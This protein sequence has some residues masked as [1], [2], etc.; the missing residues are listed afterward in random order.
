[1]IRLYKTVAAEAVKLLGGT[2]PRAC[3]ATPPRQMFGRFGPVTSTLLEAEAV[4]RWYEQAA[5]CYAYLLDVDTT[6]NEPV[7]TQLIESD[8]FT[9]GWT[10]QEL[11]APKVIE[12]YDRNWTFMGTRKSLQHAVSQASSIPAEFLSGERHIQSAFIAQRMS[13]AAS[14]KTTRPEDLAYSLLGIFDVNMPLL[15]GEGD[16]SFHRLQLE[17][18]R[19]SSDQSLFAWGSGSLLH[20]HINWDSP[21]RRQ[22]SVSTASETGLLA[23]SPAAFK[24]WSRRSIAAAFG[25]KSKISLEHS[26]SGVRM[27]VPT[28]PT[29]HPDTCIVLLDC[30]FVDDG[31]HKILGFNMKRNHASGRWYRSMP[32]TSEEESG[33]GL[34]PLWLISWS[35][36]RLSKYK[37]IDSL[38]TV[39]AHSS[40]Q[41]SAPNSL[42]SWGCVIIEISHA[43]PE[44]LVRCQPSTAYR[45]TDNVLIPSFDRLGRW[46]EISLLF[47][48]PEDERGGGSGA[49]EFA[50]VLKP[51]TLS[52]ALWSFRTRAAPFTC[53]MSPEY[54]FSGNDRV[55]A[56]IRHEISLDQEQDQ[57]VV[58]IGGPKPPFR[59][60]V[61][62]MIQNSKLPTIGY[63]YI[64]IAA[65][66]TAMAIFYPF[67]GSDFGLNKRPLMLM[68][69][70]FNGL[71]FYKF[72]YS[73]FVLRQGLRR[74]ALLFNPSSFRLRCT[75]LLLQYIWAFMLLALCIAV[76]RS[77]WQ[78]DFQDLSDSTSASYIRIYWPV[79]ALLVSLFFKVHGALESIHAPGSKLANLTA[80]MYKV[81]YSDPDFS[82][83]DFHGVY[84]LCVIICEKWF[85]NSHIL[86]WNHF[87]VYFGVML[88][89][90][91]WLPVWQAST[92]IRADDLHLQRG[93]RAT[94]YI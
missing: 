20:W 9:R 34:G 91:T 72:F 52:Q 14:R 10:L 63:L 71:L 40:L 81:N 68:S 17:I 43:I 85:P 92:M 93:G 76:F 86:T 70:L 75:F 84:F 83:S 54:S 38:T 3:T 2:L 66:L 22:T 39:R 23:P 32:S 35:T 89:I 12:F 88:V 13:W 51:C 36:A 78:E 37:R 46:Q 65:K 45:M 80:E 31:S 53:V 29:R 59:I 42:A 57:Y 4:H 69:V 21:H 58:E 50:V 18:L 19:Q 44:R 30:R 67:I 7:T 56:Q 73:P 26:N 24:R 15:Y 64:M 48:R 79:I 33:Q 41:F 8:W 27:F 77:D 28:L 6:S 1:M 82:F 5:V 61:I 74:A 49:R 25:P 87:I 62:M 60:W 16:K 55:E 47:R 90:Q 11:L 94:L